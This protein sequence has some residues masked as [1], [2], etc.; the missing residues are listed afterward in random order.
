MTSC[1][2]SA[3]LAD[4]P[5]HFGAMPVRFWLSAGSQIAD[6]CS[7]SP[8]A[9]RRA[10]DS[11]LAWSSWTQTQAERTNF[12]QTILFFFGFDPNLSGC[13]RAGPCDLLRKVPPVSRR[14][15]R[16]AWPRCILSLD[17]SG[18]LALSALLLTMISGKSRAQVVRSDEWSPRDSIKFDQRIA[19]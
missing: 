17:V 4:S 10:R 8:V 5:G 7:V 6:Q 14:P 13:A 15:H 9:V 3:R 12:S 16:S 18:F 11:L 2:R 1:G 19:T